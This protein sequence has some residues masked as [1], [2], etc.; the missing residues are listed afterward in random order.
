MNHLLAALE[1]ITC[2]KFDQ[3]AGSANWKLSLAESAERRAT[4]TPT[5]ICVLKLSKRSIDQS[6]LSD[7]ACFKGF[8]R[9]S[10]KFPG[11]NPP[12]LE[13]IK[14]HFDFT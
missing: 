12:L 1:A 11:F 14:L 9:V 10:K 8:K 3:I 2:R 7:D 4:A 13:M 5:R 6:R